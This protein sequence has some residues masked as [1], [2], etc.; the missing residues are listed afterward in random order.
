MGFVR[1]SVTQRLEK[2]QLSLMRGDRAVA[3]R[4]T[5]GVQRS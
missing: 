1:A 3:Q 5:M 4:I 2:K